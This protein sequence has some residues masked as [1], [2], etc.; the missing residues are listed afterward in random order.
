MRFA[1]PRNPSR[2]RA[3]LSHHGEGGGRRE[4]TPATLSSLRWELE[5]FAGPGDARRDDDARVT[6]SLVLRRHDATAVP[7]KLRIAAHESGRALPGAARCPAALARGLPSAGVRDV[8][9]QR[10]ATTRRRRVDDR[11]RRTLLRRA[12]RRDRQRPAGRG[13]RKRRAQGGDGRRAEVRGLARLRRR[14]PTA[15]ENDSAGERF[16]VPAPPAPFA[17]IA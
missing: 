3:S 4:T 17:R 12:R 15:R 5:R 9:D 1:I 8:G 11:R 7:V 10:H 16:P 2:T 13:S 6:R 14:P